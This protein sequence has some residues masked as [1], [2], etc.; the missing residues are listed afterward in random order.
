MG[1]TLSAH[2]L[3]NFGRFL[4]NKCH[5]YVIFQW[6]IRLLDN[7]LEKSS[8]DSYSSSVQRF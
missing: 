6:F 7:L 2:S 8:L 5:I 1:T 4:D 3:T